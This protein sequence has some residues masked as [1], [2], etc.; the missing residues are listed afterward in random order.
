MG[1]L[2]PVADALR[3][4]FTSDAAR[5][6]FNWDALP[7]DAYKPQPTMFCRRASS[8]AWFFPW[9]YQPGRS[10]QTGLPL[11]TLGM[12]DKPVE[13]CRVVFRGP[14]SKDFIYDPKTD[15]VL[16]DEDIR[17]AYQRAA[18][19]PGPGTIVLPELFR[20][21][22]EFPRIELVEVTRSLL[23]ALRLE[24][25]SFSQLKWAQVED[26][27][28]ELL[29]A[30]GLQVAATPRSH[31]G[32][33]DLIVRGEL[34]PGEPATLAVEI[35]HKSIVGVDEVSSRIHRNKDFPALLFATTGRFT[36]GVIREKQK[37]ENF[38]RLVLKDGVALRQWIQEYKR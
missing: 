1:F 11:D 26:I 22:T 30:K 29:R 19:I 35:K 4:G 24:K 2:R 9:L 18:E 23:E 27:V 20:H 38:L 17:I 13:G 31:D 10:D 25:V 21:P 34:I 3:A 12:L 37:P 6:A 33:R 36:A 28:A 16:T 8:G 7:R 32:G 15:L 14:G 5:D